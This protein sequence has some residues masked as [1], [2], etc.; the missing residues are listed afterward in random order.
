MEYENYVVAFVDVLGTKANVKT[1]EDAEIMFNNLSKIA[2]LTI[3]HKYIL[4]VSGALSH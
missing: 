3:E 2:V 1:P 4:S